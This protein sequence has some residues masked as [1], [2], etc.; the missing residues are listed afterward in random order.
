MPV[1]A[2]AF[3]ALFLITAACSAALPTAPVRAD[4]GALD[5]PVQAVSSATWTGYGSGHVTIGIMDTV[6]M[7][8]DAVGLREG[9]ELLSRPLEQAFRITWQD[10][11]TADAAGSLLK[12]KPDFLAFPTGQIEFLTT[13]GLGV[14]RIATR[15]PRVAVNAA[16]A[17]G[18]LFVTRADCDDI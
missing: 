11:V 12:N 10:V 9:F 1:R 14:C 4:H 15:K 2:G 7:S 13:S 3:L 6:S 17:V 18:S 5:W 8:V 16:E